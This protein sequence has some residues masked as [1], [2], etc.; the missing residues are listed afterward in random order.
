MDSLSLNW[1]GLSLISPDYKENLFNNN[2]Q[3][4]CLIELN[5]DTKILSLIHTLNYL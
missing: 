2:K 5:L 1:I 3:D 4:N